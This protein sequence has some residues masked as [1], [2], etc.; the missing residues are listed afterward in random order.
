FSP[1]E[2]VASGFQKKKKKKFQMTSYVI[3]IVSAKPE[4]KLA[5]LAQSVERVT[6]NF[7]RDLKVASSSLALGFIFAHSLVYSML[8]L[9]LKI[10]VCPS[11]TSS[12]KYCS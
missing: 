9:R 2:S 5:R 8:K 3:C 6:L 1:V 11:Y 4:N 12:L 10:L 7:M